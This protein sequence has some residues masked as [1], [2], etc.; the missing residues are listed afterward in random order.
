MMRTIKLI[1]LGLLAAALIALG[2]AN[3]AVVDL[4]LLPA[5]LFGES[6]SI[7]GIPLAVV[8]MAAV[9]MGILAGLMIEYLREHKI[10]RGAGQNRREIAQLRNEVTRLK[11][12]LGDDEDDLPRI[13][14]I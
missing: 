3:M 2:V 4:Y 5:K 7:K 8:I 9:L 12:K 13:P 11:A 1:V 14:A 10:R 6:Y